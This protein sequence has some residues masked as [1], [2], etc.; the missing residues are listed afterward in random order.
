MVRFRQLETGQRRAGVN[1]AGI[2]AGTR[3][4]TKEDNIGM[5][6]NTTERVTLIHLS[7]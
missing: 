5:L 6:D 7:A 2:L 4:A 1:I 3:W